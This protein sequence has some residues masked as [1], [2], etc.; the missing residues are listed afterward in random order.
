MGRFV[1]EKRRK[2]VLAASFLAGA[3]AV[4]AGFAVQGHARAAQYRRMLDNTYQHAFTELATAAGEL[5]VALRKV[6]YAT[7]PE[8]FSALCA[9][10]YSK[11]LAAQSALGE[12]PY[13]NVE[14]EQTAAFLAKTGDYAM[15][16]ARDAYG[17]TACTEAHRETLRG[18]AGAASTLSGAL[19]SLLA[20]LDAGTIRPEDVETVQARLSNATES[21]E[22]PAGSAFQTVEADF[23]E[24]PALIY[25][26][27][28]S[29]HLSC[30]TPKMLEGLPQVSEAEA[31]RAAAAFLG[32]REDIF[33]L[34]A[35]GE[36]Q[37]PTWGFS[38]AV[39][40]GE[41][42]VEV[43][44]QGAQVLQVT[45]SRPVSGAALSREAAIQ[46]AAEFL[47]Q[48][49][50]ANMDHSYSI[51]LG[52]V[53]T[54]HFAPRQDGVYCYPDLIKVSVALDNGGLIGFQSEGYLMNHRIR[55]LPAPAVTADQARSAVGD[56][57]KVLA[58]QLAVIPTGGEHEVLCHEFKC[59][60][61]TGSH[62]LVYLNAATGQEENILLLLED[63]SG[64]LTL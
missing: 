18:L 14:L 39:D 58:H 6:T 30:R 50:Y 22:L 1:M 46:A 35:Q 48:R 61:E 55:D 44:K 47:L 11:A 34:S 56:A 8:L 43:T 49:G 9:Q 19:Q 24:V 16:L 52:D 33:T 29:D 45:N 13:G 17:E 31:R 59:E 20:E 25:D 4:T 21:G 62:M 41:V 23:P 42:Y 57:L 38:A 63:E 51:D 26:G 5:D 53:L 37:L 27:P 12:L 60:T 28:F 32:L 54:V 36:G 40:G 64:T 2:Q 10:A 15:A 7:S 3:F